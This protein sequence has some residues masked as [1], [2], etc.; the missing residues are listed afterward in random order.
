[1]MVTV[2]VPSSTGGSVSYVRAYNSLV[3]VAKLA[4]LTFNGPEKILY[5]LEFRYDKG[6]ARMVCSMSPSVLEPLTYLKYKDGRY[7]KHLYTDTS[8]EEVY[9]ID[10][11]IFFYSN[12]YSG[13][14]L[15]ISNKLNDSYNTLSVLKHILATYASSFLRAHQD[16]FIKNKGTREELAEI[17][18]ARSENV[19]KMCG[20]ITAADITSLLVVGATEPKDSSRFS[21]DAIDEFKLYTG[22]SIYG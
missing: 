17:V 6:V 19:R 14:K 10:Y 11:L 2:Q 18:F 16:E 5:P 21:T 1:M 9:P 20:L 8:D 7:I 22:A 12:I 13:S 15:D 4:G 3:Q